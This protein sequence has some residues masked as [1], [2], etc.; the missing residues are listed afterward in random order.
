MAYTINK[1]SG[2]QLVVL[3]DGTVD[4][5]TSI[6]LVGRN[7]VGYGEIQNENF[8]YLLENF[9]NTNPPARPVEGQLWYNTTN[10]L[11]HV[12]D[13]GKWVIVGSAVIS[14]TPPT[15][16]PNGA[17]WYKMPYRTLHVW[18]GGDWRF[19]GPETAEGF[20][21]TR[22]RSA[23]LNDSDGGTKPVILIEINGNIVGII[24]SQ[25]FTL[26]PATAPAGFGTLIA[27]IN[28]IFGIDIKG[29]LQGK[30]ARAERLET[31]RS[32]NGTPF[33]GTSDVIVKSSTTN[34]LVRGAYLT[35]SN[36]D[37]ADQT[38]WAV[39]ATPNNLIGKVVARDSSGNFSAGTITANLVGNVQGNVTAE[40]GTS[41]FNTVSANRFIGATLTGNA[42]T[43]SR[44]ET[45]R[46]INGVS[47]DG[48]SN[49]TVPAAGETLTGVSLST[50]IKHS[51]LE[52]LGTLSNLNV[53]AEGITVGSKLKI[54]ATGSSTI[55]NQSADA[56][57]VI[58]TADSTRTGGYAS[59]SLVSS[60]ISLSNSG[61]NKPA[62]IPSAGND[63]NL[64][65]PSF[66]WGKIYANELK[67]NADTATL[68]VASTNLTGGA[69]GAI[70][71]QTAANTTTMLPLGA[72][73]TYLRASA[74]GITWSSL[75]F[76]G[77]V[78]GSY[79]VGSNYNTSSQTTWSVDA[80]SANTANKVVARD[81]SGN[82]YAGTISANLVGQVTGNA[83]TATR[84]QTPRSI[85]GVSF[86]GSSDITVTATDP[87]RVAKSG[88]SMSGYLTLVGNPV[89]GLHAATKQYVDTFAQQYTFTYG[90]TIYSQAGYTNQVGSWNN[91]ANYFDVFPPSGKSMSNLIAF[92]PSI[93]VI[94][95]A[96]GVDGN[97]SLRCTWSNL[98]DRIRVYVQNTE[99]RSTP[100]ANYLAIWS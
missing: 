55:R 7:Y 56:S 73:G 30:A 36:F 35:G 10:D 76:E 18:E 40:S 77:L 26:A 60:A 12:Y 99:Q 39:D 91:G 94:H 51:Y 66:K 74:S 19:I 17:L 75:A 84:L 14:E 64:G 16:P 53:A 48:G 5:S 6:G 1:Y 15:D 8:L 24:T 89:S 27:G 62:L 43:A 2:V 25:S 45:A 100:A 78:A 82:F 33:D 87:N 22:A 44:L 57:I 32:I 86:D 90:N 34:Y 20:G 3:E 88:D 28:L 42:A 63:I 29:N 92:I 9:A 93:A 13:G 31:A 68:S 21:R 65:H 71:Y 49:V 52:N 79:L 41:S 96:G 50:N 98:G 95:Y 97:D 69:A 23:V 58:D 59:M 80:T 54:I 61:D 38:T 83:S 11:L 70:P 37:G 81:A 4:T 47:F 85:N 72:A 46:L 67:G